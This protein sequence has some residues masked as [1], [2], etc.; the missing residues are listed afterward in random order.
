M[1][2]FW[3]LLTSPFSHCSIPP[4]FRTYSALRDPYHFIHVC[5]VACKAAVCE[6]IPTINLVAKKKQ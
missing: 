4:P 5:R 2:I 3:L 1:P 6:A